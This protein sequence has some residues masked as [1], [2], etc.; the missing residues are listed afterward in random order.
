LSSISSKPSRSPDSL[1]LR[2]RPSIGPSRAVPLT[3]WNACVKVAA[4]S[5]EPRASVVVSFQP[6]PTDAGTIH[7]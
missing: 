3:C 5:L 1:T 7:R 6:P 4:A 2:I